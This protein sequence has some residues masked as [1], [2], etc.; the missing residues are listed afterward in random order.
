[1]KRVLVSMLVC[2][3]C[4]GTSDSSHNTHVDV[5][6]VSF[7]DL[8][9]FDSGDS[10]TSVLDTSDLPPDFGNAC[11]ENTDCSSGY[12]VE[13]PSG[14]VCTRTCVDTCPDGWD[15]RAVQS[16]GADLVLLCVP[17][18]ELDHDT[19]DDTSTTGPSDVDEDIGVTS[20]ATSSGDT[21]TPGDTSSPTDTTSPPLTGNACEA[22]FGS[23][24]ATLFDEASAAAGDDFPD[25]V[26]GCSHAAQT[27]LWEIDLRS[28]NYTG[29]LGMIDDEQHNLEVGV[30]PDIDIIAIRAE[31]R[32]MIEFAVQKVSAGG[33]MDPVAYT[34]DGFQIRTYSSDVSPTNQC[35]R[36][37]IAYPYVGAVPIYIVIEDATNYDQY[38]PSGY[39]PGTVGGSS[40]GYTLRI[41]T[42][43]FDPVE[44]GTLAK[45]ASATSNGYQLTLGG[46]TRYFRFYA[47]G[48]DAAGTPTRPKVTITRAAGASSS[49]TLAA[50]G[51]KTVLGALEW[52]SAKYDS[53]NSGT[54]KLDQPTSFRACKPQSECPS[55]FTCEEPQC[56][57]ALVEFVFAVQDWNGAADPGAF[58][59][60]VSVQIP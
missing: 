4:S 40:Y 46:E 56:T 39:G 32:T 19:A 60:D 9:Q 20:D 2:V 43:G 33:L 34:S 57:T 18:G 35:A 30:G 52:Q 27:G 26:T 53:T 55:G 12:C 21:S 38:S 58:K 36:T 51:M 54:V 7:S 41:R 3:G 50:A 1:M 28:G 8:S 37:T 44:L 49:F 15:C 42:G 6:D 47:P 17:T 31:P 13:G 5:P 23:G 29:A 45:G 25:C 16:G 24:F 22:D 48:A 10:G 14:F 11:H 59:Y